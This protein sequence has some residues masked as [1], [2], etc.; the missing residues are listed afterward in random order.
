[1]GFRVIVPDTMGYGGTDAP[2][3][4]PNSLALYSMKRA[5]DDFALL[6]R[7]LGCTRNL[8]IGGHDWGGMIIW[9]M[10][11]WHPD[12]V[13]HVFSVCSPYQRPHK[14]YHSTEEIAKVAP[15]FGYQLHLAGPEVEGRIKTKEDIRK[16]LNGMFG[17][18]GPNRESIFDPVKGVLFENLDKIGKT[19]L[20]SDEEMDYYVEQYSRNGVHGTVNWY[21]TRKVNFDEELALKTD[22]VEQP[23]LFIQALKD[24]VLIPDMARGMEKSIPKLTIEKVNASHWALVEKPAEINAILEKWL[25]ETVLSPKSSL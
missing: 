5:S 20:L 14:T 6:A 9:R 16:W 1:M 11:Q 22:R 17:A 7:Q 25:K 3:V 2:H 10:A 15:R 19:R 23:V 18:R 8:I 24:N 13:S 21:R 4:P 12:L